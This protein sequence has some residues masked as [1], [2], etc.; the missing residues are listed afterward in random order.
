MCILYKIVSYHVQFGYCN[1]C[2]LPQ[3][4]YYTTDELWSLG[5]GMKYCLPKM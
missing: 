2:T 1:V 5:L 3:V 4:P